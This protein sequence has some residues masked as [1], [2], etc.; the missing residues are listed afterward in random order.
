[1]QVR[2]LLDSNAGTMACSL[3]V[4]L[5]KVIVNSFKCTL[6]FKWWNNYMCIVTIRKYMSSK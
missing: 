4:Q 6:S 1:M 3:S 2:T 5:L